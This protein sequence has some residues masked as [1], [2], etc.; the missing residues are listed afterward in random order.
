MLNLQRLK[1]LKETNANDSLQFVADYILNKL[2]RDKSE[3]SNYV[4]EDDW[5]E[6][7]QYLQSLDSI[8]RP[9]DIRLIKKVIRE[10]SDNEGNLPS[11]YDF[12]KSLLHRFETRKA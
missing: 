7:E 10:I 12:E 11:D 4:Q 9:R 5:T 6:F 2:Q 1:Y 8:K 3:F